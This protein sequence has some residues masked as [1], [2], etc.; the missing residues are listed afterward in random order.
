MRNRR[1]SSVKVQTYTLVRRSDIRS[2]D[3]YNFKTVLCHNCDAPLLDDIH[4][5]CEFCGAFINDGS[6][7]WVLFDI[8]P[9]K[10]YNYQIGANPFL[11]D[12]TK[13]KGSLQSGKTVYK[14]K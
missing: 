7:D 1:E 11:K 5:Q 8:S 4:A 12:R 14:D 10:S 6:R 9:Y 13:E 2:S 3:Y